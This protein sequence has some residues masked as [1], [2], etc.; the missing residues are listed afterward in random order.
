[1]RIWFNH[2]FS[3]A[4][5]LI[6]LM[7]AGVP[8]T[9]FVLG[10]NRNP[11]ALYREVCDEW[12]V[13]P[14]CA[15]DDEYTAFCLDFCRKHKVEILVPRHRL[16]AL[17]ERRE[18]F[19]R[20]GVRLLC[21]E[22]TALLR[23]LDDKAH[24]YALFEK[25]GF[26]CVPEH[27]VVRSVGKFRQACEELRSRYGRICYKLTK[28]EGAS[29]FRVLDEMLD[30][31]GALFRV[32][33]AKIATA[34]AECILAAYDFTVPVLVMPWLTGPEISVDCLA[35]KQGPL[36]LPRYKSNHRYETIRFDESLMTLCRQILE[37][38]RLNAPLNLQFRLHKGKLFLLEINPRMS[39]G[40]Q[41]ACAATAINTPALALKQMLGWET[42]WRYPN[43]RER[44]V[45]HIE[46]PI[47]L[48]TGEGETP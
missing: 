30:Q 40:L 5:H 4:Y 13:E 1:M 29:T 3:T 46:T 45:A 42:D 2:W 16:I 44:R 33:G 48:D 23:T 6:Q 38:L 14:N 25:W 41:L 8:E 22:N 20:E 15:D 24:T 7:R 21:G 28:D 12:H 11:L 31:A 37:H 9:L 47:C 18:Q 26:D 35:T 32:P 34:T 36:I 43:W 19:S 27:R 39:G 17:A 10:S